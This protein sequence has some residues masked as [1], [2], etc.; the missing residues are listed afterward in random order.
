MPVDN[1]SL[2]QGRKRTTPH[3]EGQFTAY[4][5]SPLLVSKSS[6]LFQLLVRMYRFAKQ[7]VINLHPIGF[8]D[9]ANASEMDDSEETVELHVSLTRPTYL[10]AQQ[11]EDF[12][13]AVRNAARSRQK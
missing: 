4:V 6:K 2:H 3:V 11:R 13:R 5:Y 10:R 7:G 8:P 1:P 12:K 9:T